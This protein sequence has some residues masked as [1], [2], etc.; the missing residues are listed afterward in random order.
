M[1]VLALPIKEV[2]QG[3]NATLCWAAVTSSLLDY[4]NQ[5]DWPVSRVLDYA[6]CGLEHE[7]GYLCTKG[8]G[9]CVNNCRN[10][11]KG[12]LED[13]SGAQSYCVG[14]AISFE[15]IKSEINALRPLVAHQLLRDRTYTG[16]YVIIC[17]YSGVA[18][19]FMNPTH[20]LKKWQSFTFFAESEGNPWQYHNTL[21]LEN[22]P[23]DDL[24]PVTL[25]W[26]EIKYWYEDEDVAQPGGGCELFSIPDPTEADGYRCEGGMDRT[27]KSATY[28][29]DLQ[30]RDPLQ[31]PL[32]IPFLVQSGELEIKLTLSASREWIGESTPKGIWSL[33]L[34]NIFFVYDNTEIP[35]EWYVKGWDFGYC[36]PGASQTPQKVFHY[37]IDLFRGYD[38]SDAHIRVDPSGH[39]DYVTTVY[40]NGASSDIAFRPD[41]PLPPTSS[42][43]THSP[44]CLSPDQQSVV[45]NMITEHRTKTENRH[46]PCYDD[47]TKTFVDWGDGSAYDEIPC[48]AGSADPEHFYNQNGTYERSLVGERVDYGNPLT[49]YVYAPAIDRP[50]LI[51]L[52]YENPEVNISNEYDYGIVRND[53]GDGG[54]WITE[55]VIDYGDGRVIRHRPV[56]DNDEH[57]AWRR[58]DEQFAFAFRYDYSEAGTFPLTVKAYGTCPNRYDEKTT[59]IKVYADPPV[60]SYTA[61]V[62][63]GKGS[64]TST[65]SGSNDGGPVE[66]WRWN[67]GDG[68]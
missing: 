17:D 14:G 49:E 40:Y 1:P 41:G 50:P 34:C 68:K 10:S 63:Q 59:S 54:G 21:V 37:S 60:V 38:Y 9:S 3:E 57:E 46:V 19:E 28:S 16:H 32:D 47:G 56:E 36:E 64:V 67:F 27:N 26:D 11:I 5:K 2:Y 55:W 22:S 35:L 45:E 48:E 29:Q 39:G 58:W 4:Y 7:W 66:Q 25:D 65:F 6:V 12:L 52:D 18:I 33:E 31:V 24:T 43:N 42:N 30:K 15:D 53:V 61:D 23:S 62:Q 20:G 44:T 8:C 13:L 51:S